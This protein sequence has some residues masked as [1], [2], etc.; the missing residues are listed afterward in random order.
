VYSPSARDNAEDARNA[1]FK[2]FTE[3]PGRAT[4]NALLGL[5]EVPGFPIPPQRLRAL[6]RERASK[7]AE[8][9]PWP[10]GEAC[11]FEDKCETLPQTPLDLQRLLLARFS[12]LQHSLLHDDFAQGSTLYGLTGERA[13]QNW[14]GYYLRHSQG[15]SY[16]IER[17][18]HVVDENEPDIRA[19]SANDASVPIEVK[20]AE[21]WTLD[22]LEAALVDQLCGR[23]L[24]AR[25]GR[26]GILLLVH[27]KAR[28]RG[29]TYPKDGRRLDFAEVVEHLH[30]LAKS[31]A[32]ADADT[33]Q[34]EIAVIDVSNCAPT[35]SPAKKT[36]AAKGRRRAVSK[37]S[38]SG[39]GEPA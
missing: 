24:R 13:V 21:S 18:P 23:Y 16:S 35:K 32:G 7:D 5:S 25:G 3:I 2:Q 12:D 28:P 20:V 4:F 11:A 36:S 39:R 17:E 26:H 14:M 31:I 29:W 19:R 33:P 27:Q 9:A 10:P 22:K 37:P 30:E 6:A 34:P 8:A 38:D 1:A 15:R